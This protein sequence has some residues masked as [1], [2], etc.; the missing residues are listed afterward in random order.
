MED[1]EFLVRGNAQ[2]AIETENLSLDID[3]LRSGVHALFGRIPDAAFIMI[4]EANG[5]PVGQMM[6]TYEWS[7]WCATASSGGFKVYT[8]RPSFDAAESFARCMPQAEALARQERLVC[9]LRNLYA[10]DENNQRAQATAIAAAACAKLPIA[11][12]PKSIM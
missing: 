10:I 8:P 11:C 5:T 6:I 12:S 9:G 2:L 4:A 7:D 1:A 3:R